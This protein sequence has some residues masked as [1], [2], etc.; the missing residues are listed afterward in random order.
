[1]ARGFYRSCLVLG[2]CLWIGSALIMAGCRNYKIGEENKQAQKVDLKEVV[3]APPENP[4]WVE[5][6][7]VPITGSE[8]TEDKAVYV[9]LMDAESKMATF[10][11]LASGS[12]LAGQSGQEL[13]IRGMAEQFEKAASMPKN[14]VPPD[15]KVGN[16]V[17][18]ENDTPPGW[19]SSWGLMI[20]G[21]IIIGGPSA[22]EAQ[23]GGT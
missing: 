6:K 14:N 19:W 5:V 1:M 9:I 13:T 7:G 21:F 15:V 23:G 17:I 18:A 3:T 16:L 10:V 11:R 22:N 20:L 8:V 2:T 4:K 12:T